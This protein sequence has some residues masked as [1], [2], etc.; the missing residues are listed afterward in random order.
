MSTPGH[1]RSRRTLTQALG[2]TTDKMKAKAAD[3]APEMLE[4]GVKGSRPAMLEQARTQVKQIGT[5][6]G[7]EIK[8]AT[9][10]GH[11]VSGQEMR[12]V[13]VVWESDFASR[14]KRLIRQDTMNEIRSVFMSEADL[15]GNLL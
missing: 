12:E 3:L 1:H 6:I 13:E 2:A 10:A 15:Q 8:V 11:A 14:R 7:A 5:D 9:D 4:R